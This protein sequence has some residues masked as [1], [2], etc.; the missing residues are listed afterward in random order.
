M[1]RKTR[2]GL[3]SLALVAG[4]L[5]HAFVG[6]YVS[7]AADRGVCE[8][9]NNPCT[10][11]SCDANGKPNHVPV[12]DAADVAC[13]LGENEGVCRSGSCELNCITSMTTCKCSTKE[14][15]PADTLCAIWQCTI[16]TCVST[17][18]MEGMTAD[19]L[20]PG[21]CQKK[22]CQG[23]A[24]KIV[25]DPADT[26]TD[27]KGDCQDPVCEAGVPKS[28]ANDNDVP[29]TDMAGDC[30]KPA[31]NA[32]TP[33]VGVDE[34]DPPAPTECST[35]TC[36]P[37]GTWTAANKNV[38]D[39]CSNGPMGEPRAC[40]K[41]GMCVACLPA[42][43]DD[44]DKC[45]MNNGGVCPIKL[46][47]G[48]MAANAS[49]CISGII[50][51]KVCCEN[52]CTDECKSC[53]L[54]GMEGKCTNVP[55]YGVD[56]SFTDPVTMTPNLTCDNAA[57]CDGVGKCLRIVS[58]ICTLDAQCM[59]GKCAMPAQVCLGAP[60]EICNGNAQCVSN[61]CVVGACK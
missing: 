26:P 33:G 49:E 36:K 28:M 1:I 30:M 7:R 47:V 53:A 3:V 14:D 59:S 22:V 6:C 8:D 50:A 9:D 39:V 25:D 27:V 21:D 46:C 57:R 10:E 56:Y 34:Q 55:Y 41:Q 4:I 19:P 40:D 45:K 61:M 2:F 60:G 23:G 15:C 11:D 29:M 20:Q 32:G 16:G 44:Y 31:C 18:V 51:D 24:L 48:E 35:F 37:D 38:G 52:T 58:T 13:F 43:K 5:M 42:G 12:E 54:P 17:A